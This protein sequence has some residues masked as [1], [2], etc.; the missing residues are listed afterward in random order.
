M[1]DISA[2]EEA[3]AMGMKLQPECGVWLA[4]LALVFIDR[5]TCV[6]S[7][8]F[9]CLGYLPTHRSLTHVCT[10]LQL[11]MHKLAKWVCVPCS[12][13]NA[14]LTHLLP[15]PSSKLL[16]V[17]RFVVLGFAAST[18]HTHTLTDTLASCRSL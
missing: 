8:L 16:P 3:L 18:T 1:E 5:G 15:T 11:N 6:S 4:Q 13:P 7:L 2:A 14:T 10:V 9:L 17:R 12:S